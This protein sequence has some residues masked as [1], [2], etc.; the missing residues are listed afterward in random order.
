MIKLKA[1]FLRTKELLSSIL[2]NN[3]DKGSHNLY[4]FSKILLQ[5]PKNYSKTLKRKSPSLWLDQFSQHLMNV[6]FI[7]K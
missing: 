1:E 7:F 5:L 4:S 3:N 6:F 2:N